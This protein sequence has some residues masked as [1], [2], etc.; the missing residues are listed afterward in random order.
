M[1]HTDSTLNRPELLVGYQHSH[2]EVPFRR[3][4][5]ALA[6]QNEAVTLGLHELVAIRR[7]QFR[8]RRH[9]SHVVVGDQQCGW[10]MGNWSDPEN[11]CS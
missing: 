10:T 8:Q 1:I 4:R 11:H 7:D 5:I 6:G 2:C 9:E 3:N